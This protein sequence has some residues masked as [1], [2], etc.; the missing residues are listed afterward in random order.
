MEVLARTSQLGS[1][2]SKPNITDGDAWIG[3]WMADER[4][5]GYVSNFRY[6]IGAVL[7]I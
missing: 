2:A 4:F 5:S 1:E 3:G 6:V 7:H